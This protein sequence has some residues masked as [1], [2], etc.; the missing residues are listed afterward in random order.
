[1]NNLLVSLLAILAG[2]MLPLQ[3]AMNAMLAKAVGSPI[4]AAAIS[5]GVGCYGAIDTAGA[6]LWAKLGTQRNL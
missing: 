1:M 6:V 4:R 3:A 2:G 5:G